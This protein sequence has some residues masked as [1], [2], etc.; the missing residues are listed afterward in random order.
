[1]T[2]L[3]SEVNEYIEYESTSPDLVIELTKSSNA[4]MLAQSIL[5][6]RELVEERKKD[7]E[8]L[9]SGTLD[10]VEQLI[11]DYQE[12]HER[13]KLDLEYKKIAEIEANGRFFYCLRQK[14]QD[15]K[16]EYTRK[17]D[18]NNSRTLPD[19]GRTSRNDKYVQQAIS[20]KLRKRKNELN[21]SEKKSKH[22]VSI[23]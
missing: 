12:E 9:C 14:L 22:G 17:V 11:N 2:E 21:S 19:R 16:T 4:W 13:L 20:C 18:E 6:L 10:S 3:S 7:L 8:E 1:M 15:Q 23:F 5:A